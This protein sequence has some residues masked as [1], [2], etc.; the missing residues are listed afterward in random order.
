MIHSSSSPIPIPSPSPSTVGHSPDSQFYSSDESS[1]TPTNTTYIMAS[2]QPTDESRSKTTKRFGSALQQFPQDLTK[3]LNWYQITEKLTDKNFS[4]WSQP[5]LEALM[6]LDYVKY[7]KKA[8]YKDENLSEAEHK[9]VK[10]IVT[11]WLLS[12]MD[13]ENSRRCRVHLTTQSSKGDDDSEELE[14]DSDD[15]SLLIMTYKPSMLW[16][17]LKLHHQAISESSLSVI[18][19]TL[20]ALKISSSDSIVVHMDKLTNL[21]LD[22]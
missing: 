21:M 13:A 19:E 12:L 20:H 4:Q 3:S 16:K 14:E 22:Y 2:E 9:K 1:H 6:S 8:S 11:T 10:F 18:N 7:V 5:V 15:D 17:F